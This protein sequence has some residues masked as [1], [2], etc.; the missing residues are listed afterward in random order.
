MDIRRLV[1]KRLSWLLVLELWVLT[2]I[3][4]SQIQGCSI[5]GID[6][7]QC[8]NQDN[9]SSIDICCKSLNQV[10]RAGYNCLC[11]LLAPSIPVLSSPLSLPLSNCLIS[12]PPL[13]LCQVLAPMPV[14][15][16]PVPVEN[17]TQ[18]S[19][20]SQTAPVPSSPTEVQVPLNTRRGDNST[21]VAMRPESIEDHVPKLKC[22]VSK[23]G[24]NESA[25]GSDGTRKL[26]H[27]SLFLSLALLG[28]ILLA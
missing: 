16:P 22:N 20:P 15:I 26:L 17:L 11:S 10:V 18:P 21:A 23:G 2:P 27:R 19:A 25:N 12:V 13:S 9:S 5:E 28:C 8:L 3:V 4:N 1:S 6:L 24:L 14:V 7:L